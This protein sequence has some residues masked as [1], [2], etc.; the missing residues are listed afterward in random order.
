VGFSECGNVLLSI[1]LSICNGM[2]NLLFFFLLLLIY[3]F[4]VP[5]RRES[6]GESVWKL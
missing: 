1:V 6:S 3:L 5:A 4:L 2:N